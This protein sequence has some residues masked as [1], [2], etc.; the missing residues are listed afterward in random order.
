MYS[1]FHY[2]EVYLTNSQS[3]GTCLLLYLLASVP[4]SRIGDGLCLCLC[5]CLQGVDAL[6][7]ASL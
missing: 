1:L 5:L 3:A 7:I 6:S 2:A 4:L